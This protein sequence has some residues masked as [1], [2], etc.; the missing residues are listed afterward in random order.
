MHES[1]ITLYVNGNI[2][3]GFRR[4]QVQLSLEQGT[5]T[6]SFDYADQWVLDGEPIRI[7]EGDSCQVR[8]GEEVLLDGYVDEARINYDADR[9]AYSCAGRAKTADLVDCSIENKRSWSN[10]LISDIVADI[11][12]SFGVLT[13]L[14]GSPGDRFSSFVAKPGDTAWATIQRAAKRRGFLPYTMGGDLVLSRAG[15]NRTSTRIKRGENVISGER[16][17]SQADRYSKYVFQ[18]QTGH[19]KEGGGRTAAQLREDI[20]DP[21][22]KRYRPLTVQ[23]GGDGAGDMRTRAMLERNYRIG[24]SDRLS[25]TV[26]GWHCAEGLWQPN[27]L[28][29][30]ED[31]WLD[32]SADLLVVSVTFKLDAETGR[33]GY[34]TELDLTRPEAFDMENF[35]A[36]GRKGTWI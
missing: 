29:R 34:V 35:P 10:A 21:D 22:V 19:R 36:Q 2:H 33:G 8:I 11:S 25:F 1:P 16:V 13:I 31:D 7:H 3:G 6:F 32:V 18:G 20:V 24:R 12:E 4:G 9:R 30:V 28:V 14:A 15:A 26:P 27:T 23:A 17:N 5:N